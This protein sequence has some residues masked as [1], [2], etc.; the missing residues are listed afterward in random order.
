MTPE[1]L[2]DLV[3]RGENSR[4]EI[5]ASIPIPR[6][7]AQHIAAM[8]NTDGGHF[9]IGIEEPN[10]RISGTDPERAIAAITRAIELVDPKP[11]VSVEKIIANGL[12]VIVATIGRS[13]ATT[14]AGNGYYKRVGHRSIALTVR[15]IEERA[16]ST[17][18]LHASV[19]D[20]SAQVA[21][22]TKMTESLNNTVEELRQEIKSANAWWKKGLYAAIGAA[23]T[24]GLKLL[25][26]IL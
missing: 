7:I 24:Y 5:K 2:F 16:L 22:H 19:S 1:Q 14:S 12:P 11:N 9:V 20:L 3:Q 13:N 6:S 10:F 15:D 8:A 4:L 23:V 21:G 18:S 26:G 17:S 25:S